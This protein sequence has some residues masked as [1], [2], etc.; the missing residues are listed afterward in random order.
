MKKMLKV[1]LATLVLGWAVMAHAE[2]PQVEY[3]DAIGKGDMKVVKKYF[4]NPYKVDELFFAWTALEIAANKGQLNAVK[5]FV[6]NGAD[7]NYKHPITKMTAL[8]L[9]A[10]QGNKE[11]VKYLIDHGA[12]VNAKLRGNVSIIRALKDE[13]RT[14]MVEFLTA[15][16]A[17]NDGCQEE[18]CH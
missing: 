13:G 4:N 3:T 1:I 9:A 7:V 10:Y 12:D 16:G 18:K 15:A 17:K 8:H 6:E 14:D 5:F 11:V 2:D